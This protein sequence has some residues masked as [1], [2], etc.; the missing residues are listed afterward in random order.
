MQQ[1][2]KH[3]CLDCGAEFDTREQLDAHQRSQ[4]RES[5]PGSQ[6]NPED[7]SREQR[8]RQDRER[9]KRM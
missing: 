6:P 8:D 5:R 2:Q 7:R 4:H 9:Q 3:R 1:T